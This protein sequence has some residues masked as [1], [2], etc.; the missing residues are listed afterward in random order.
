[1]T[2]VNNGRWNVPGGPS[3]QSCT[4]PEIRIVA[5]SEECLVET[6][7]LFKNPAMVKGCAG[8]RPENFL[9]F[10]VLANVSLHC[11]SAAIL[12]VPINQVARF[13]NDALGILKQDFAGEH[14]NA[15]SRV[16]ISDQF[17]KPIRFRNSIAVKQS[18]PLTA[19]LLECQV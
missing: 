12:A 9:G 14:S 7:G 11:A 10:I 6:T 13:V 16:A 2:M 5:K 3:E 19:G 1:M 15:A 8:V 4:Q 17:L 18:D